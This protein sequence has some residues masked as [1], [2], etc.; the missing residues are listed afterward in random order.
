MR[1]AAPGAAE[2]PTEAEVAALHEEAA[3]LREQLEAVAARAEAGDSAAAEL[4]RVRFGSSTKT[5]LPSSREANTALP[6]LNLQ[7]C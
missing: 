5:T 3:E 4:T 7:E 2:Q 1:Y 6:N